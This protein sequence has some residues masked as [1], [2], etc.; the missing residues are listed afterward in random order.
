M[1]AM[2]WTKWRQWHCM[3]RRNYWFNSPE[4]SAKADESH[5]NWLTPMIANYVA[6]IKHLQPLPLTFLR[7]HMPVWQQASRKS[8]SATLSWELQKQ[9]RPLKWQFAQSF[10]KHSLADPIITLSPPWT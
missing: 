6:S 2:R 9:W 8:G 5:C 10:C 1:F 4:G 3:K 7:Q